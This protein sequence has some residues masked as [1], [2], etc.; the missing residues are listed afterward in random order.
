MN[1]ELSLDEM[2]QWCCYKRKTPAAPS[3]QL[4]Y[5]IAVYSIL[6]T[7]YFLLSFYSLYNCAIK[8][9]RVNVEISRERLGQFGQFFNK[10]IRQK[11]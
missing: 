11:N 6:F 1:I 9:P 3:E 10:I 2:K 5:I 4:R 7:D 8:T